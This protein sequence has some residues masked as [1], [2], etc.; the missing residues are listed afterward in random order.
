MSNARKLR[1]L[2]LL[3]VLLF[4]ALDAWLTKFRTTSWERT[5][6]VYVY[7]LAFDDSDVTRRY[8]EHLQRASFGPIEAFLRREGRAYGVA[9]DPPVHVE[10]GRTLEELPPLPPRSGN[11][12]GVGWWSLKLRWWAH[13]ME[14][15]QLGPRGDVRLFVIYHDPARQPALEHSL[16]LQKGL[17]GVVHAFASARMAGSN[18]VIIAHELLHTLGAT[19]KYD[20]ATGLPSF[21]IGYAEPDRQ[22]LHPQELAELMAG[23]I[24]LSARQAE[25]PESLAEVR[26]GPASALEI[27]W[28]R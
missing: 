17:V 4:V 6:W 26:I 5:L 13:R 23:R 20:L 28:V 19:D 11:P 25:I 24:P 9:I 22:P 3:L 21:P 7:P 1:I 8:V 2:L 16:G 10:R 15:G 12:F 14:A 27:G 18:N